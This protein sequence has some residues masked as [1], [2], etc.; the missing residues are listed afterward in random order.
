MKTKTNVSITPIIF[1]MFGVLFQKE[2]SNDGQIHIVPI[3]E[4]VELLRELAAQTN[5]KDNR[6][7]PCYLLSNASNSTINALRNQYP[8]IFALF[9]GIVTSQDAGFSKPDTRMYHYLINTFNLHK[10]S[11][12]I[13]DTLENVIAAE[14]VGLIGIQWTNVTTVHKV[15]KQLGI[16]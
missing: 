13:D 14:H 12:F 7:N 2:Y 11:I 4:G 10:P 15:L 3:T 16:F 8:D 1:D 5:A 6:S 9:D